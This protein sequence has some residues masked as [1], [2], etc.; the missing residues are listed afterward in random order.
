MA[1]GDRRVHHLA[2][3]GTSTYTPPGGRKERVTNIAGSGLSELRMRHGSRDNVVIS[4]SEQQT[5]FIQQ[6]PGYGLDSNVTLSIGSVVLAVIDGSTNPDRLVFVNPLDVGSVTPPFGVKGSLASG[7]NGVRGATVR[8]G[9]LHV[10]R[11]N[12]EV[13]GVNTEDPDSTTSP[14]GH[15]GTLSLPSSATTFGPHG[16]AYTSNRLIIV[17][18]DNTSVRVRE[19]GVDFAGSGTEVATYNPTGSHRPSVGGCVVDGTD[20]YVIYTLGNTNAEYFIR[21]DT[22][23]YSNSA[24]TYR[25][26]QQLPSLLNQPGGAAITPSGDVYMLGRLADDIWLVDLNDADSETS[27]YGRKGVIGVAG[28]APQALAVVSG[29]GA[30]AT[31]RVSTVEVA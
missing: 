29:E 4:P 15:L 30:P 16:L 13:H 11:S 10:L 22:T 1:L 5:P 27:P 12:G 18:N 8:N 21:F 26:P 31:V 2:T 17:F 3:G 20:L 14:Y 7:L 6:N 25:T 23:N 28:I 9:V 24:G 19:Y